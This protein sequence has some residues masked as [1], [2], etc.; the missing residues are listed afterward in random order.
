VLLV[1][2]GVIVQDSNGD[3]LLQRR[4]DGTGWGIPG[5]CMELG[6]SLEDTAR[7]ELRE[8]TGLVAGE[9]TLLDVYSGPDFFLE[10]PNGDQA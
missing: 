4:A 5:G 9:M 6:E 10:F 1:A 7:R 2:A 3:I 8:E